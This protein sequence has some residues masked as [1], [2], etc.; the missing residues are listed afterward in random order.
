MYHYIIVHYY[1]YS[2]YFADLWP[3]VLCSFPTNMTQKIQV[4]V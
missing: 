2:I 3:V 4:D 1:S